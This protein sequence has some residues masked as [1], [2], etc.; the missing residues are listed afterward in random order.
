M[1]AFEAVLERPKWQLASLSALGNK[2]DGAKN[3]IKEESRSLKPTSSGRLMTRPEAE[4]EVD[5]LQQ[6]KTKRI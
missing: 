4:D 5:A 3:K 2:V 6:D 1:L